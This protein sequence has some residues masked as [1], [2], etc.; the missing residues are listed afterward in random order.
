MPRPETIL[1][2][3]PISPELLEKIVQ[4]AHGARVFGPAEHKERKDAW[5]DAEVVFTHHLQPERLSEAPKLRWIQTMG[6]GV[7]WLLTPEVVARSELV[8]TNA[9]GV[10]ADPIAEHVFSLMLAL[11]RRLPEVLALQRESRWDTSRF[12]QDV[13]TLAGATLGILGVGAIGLR[14]AAIGAA[15]GMRVIGMRRGAEPAAHVERMYAPSQLQTLLSESHYVVDALPLTPATR[16]LLGP[17][18]FA[19]MRSDAVLINIGRG[20]SV[21]TDAL[22]EALRARRIAGAGLDVTDP[23][24]LP[25]EHPLWKMENVIITPHYSGGRPGYTE[26]V[27]N[28]FLENLRRY[29]AGEALTNLVD[30]RAGY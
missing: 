7:E 28:I 5:R 24:P 15:F 10:H 18:E 12:L 30:K 29:I 1:V 4:Q 13:P 27:T 2:R 22:V 17:A 3:A 26:H 21:Q 11:A 6:A 8:I 9:S 14:I 20:G 16:G 19:A 23:E 25:P